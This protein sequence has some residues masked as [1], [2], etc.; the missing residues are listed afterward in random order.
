MAAPRAAW[1]GFLR[2]GSVSCGVKIVG[3]VTEA[4]KIHFN[5]LNRWTGNKVR[6]VYVD[7]QTSE[8][9]PPDQQQK[10]WEAD[11]DNFIA[12]DSQEIKAL[13]LTSEHTLDVDEFVPI[14]DIDTRY[15]EKPYYLLPA[16]K[17]STEAFT[18]LREAM[19]KTKMAARSC[20]VMYQHGHEVVIQPYGKGMLLTWMRPYNQVTQVGDIFKGIPGGKQDQ[21]LID[22]AS[23]L[24]DKKLTT[25]DPSRFEDRYEEAL[26]ELIDA[27]R[28]GKELPKPKAPPKPENVVNLA[29]I[30][31]KSLT[32]EGLVPR[33]RG[34]SSK[35]SKA[36]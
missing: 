1:T 14:S 6:S 29:D 25:F 17:P 20:V 7:E 15:L 34:K 4:E 11:K 10:G 3:V 13:K 8:Q 16:D 32:A 36:A 23:M 21:E 30:L 18:V 19:E 22:V 5:I 9:V 28:K 12:I 26:A 33:K 24:I 27:K 35:K 2:V 31:K